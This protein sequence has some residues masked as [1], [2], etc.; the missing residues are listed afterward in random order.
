MKFCR[1]KGGVLVAAVMVITVGTV[2]LWAQESRQ[3]DRVIHRYFDPGLWGDEQHRSTTSQDEH[4][5]SRSARR[6]S[7]RPGDAPGLWLSPGQGEWILTAEG[8]LGP[9]AVEQ[10]HGNLDTPQ[11]Q[12]ELDDRTDRVDELDYQNNFDPSVVPF[13]RGVVQDRI[14]HSGDGSYAAYLADSSYRTVSTGGRLR[15]GEERF[16]GSFL[17]RIEPETRQLIP[18]VAPHQRV[19]SVDSEPELEV[20]IER[21][22]ADNFY[23]SGSH[24]EL[25]RV[26]LE[27]AVQRQY[28][29]GAMDGSV[30]WDDFATFNGLDD[31][32]M[33]RRAGEVVEMIGIDPGQMSPLQALER[34]V[35]YHRGFEARPYQQRSGS[36]LYE[37]ISRER[38]GVCRHRSLTFMI[39]AHFLGI[40]TR[41]VY[42]EAHAFVE[43]YWPG[44]GWRR[45]DLGGAADAFNYHSDGGGNVHDGIWDWEF[46]RPDIYEE[47]IA[48]LPG[49]GGE[50]AGGE[51][52][53]AVEASEQSGDE[54]PLEHHDELDPFGGEEGGDMAMPQGHE[55]DHGVSDRHDHDTGEATR[56]QVVEADGAVY[57]GQPMRVRGAV[58]QVDGGEM[59]EVFLLPSGTVQWEQ[60]L[61]LGTATVD[62][63]GKFDEE[64]TIPHQISLGRWQ[65]RGRIV[66]VP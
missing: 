24:D 49:G 30:G 29:D 10:P 6:P 55:G 7:S 35:E 54:D 51:T 37:E 31:E 13:K 18:S 60:G 38:V 36:D 45:I 20:T 4:S 50:G 33:R 23:L 64:W 26:N 9:E 14:R 61:R 43:V 57:R 52:G 65:L 3:G 1:K 28:F 48:N 17:V 40:N 66:E 47:E 27:L 63:D 32:A 15:P 39:S 19:L 46:P 62:A 58:E 2:P 21:D 25:V 59:V 12:T 16:W 42:N 34:L 53:A 8:P 56:V 44:Q 5:E 11:G 22:G 41:Y